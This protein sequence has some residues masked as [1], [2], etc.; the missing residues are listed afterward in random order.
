MVSLG[1]DD[2]INDI[3]PDN[4][5]VPLS[6]SVSSIEWAPL[7]M[8]NIFACVCWDGTLQVYEMVNTGYTFAL[9]QKIN[10]KA[11]SPLTKCVWS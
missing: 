4:N 8:G 6:D 2:Y 3:R 1:Q 5:S 10:V 9:S 11:K 7:S